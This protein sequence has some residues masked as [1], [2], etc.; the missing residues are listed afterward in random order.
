MPPEAGQQSIGV[1]L[2]A[3]GEVFLRSESGIRQ[4]EAGAEVFRGEELVTGS[5][6]AAEVRFVDDTLLSQGADSKI[7]LDDYVFSDS[8]SDA[9]LLFKMSQG[10]FRMVTGKIA[11]QNPDRFQVGTPLATI[12]IRGTTIISEIIPGGGEK[13]GVEEI[14]AGKALLV[15]SLSGEIRAISSPRELVDIAVSGQLGSVRSMSLAEFNSFREIAPSA[16]QQEREIRQQ[17]EEQQDTPENQVPEDQDTED[18]G[19]N[20][21]GGDEGQTEGGEIGGPVVSGEG[22]LNPAGGVLDPGA[23]VVAHAIGF[24]GAEAILEQLVEAADPESADEVVAGLEELAEEILEAVESGDGEAVQ[25][26]LNALGNEVSEIIDELV[27]GNLQQFAGQTEEQ[28]LNNIGQVLA[29][30]DVPE[31]NSE[32]EG[33]TYTSSDGTNFIHGDGSPWVGTDNDDYYFGAETCESLSGM[34]GNDVIYGN[35]GNDTISGGTGNDSVTGNGGNDIITGNSGN[36]VLSGGAGEDTINGGGGT[37]TISGGTEDDVII[38][39]SGYYDLVDGGDG[40]DTLDLSEMSPVHGAFVNLVSSDP[41]LPNNY[42]GIASMDSEV[43]FFTDIERVIGTAESDTILGNG[44]DNDFFGGDGADSISGAGGN[45]SLVG[46]AGIDTLDGGPGTDILEGGLGSDILDGGSDNDTDKFWYNLLAEAGDSIKN[47]AAGTDKFMFNY[48]EFSVSSP[49][50]PCVANSGYDGYSGTVASGG[51]T[52]KV[53]I[54]VDDGV[55][56]N[57]DYLWYDDNGTGVSGGATL[58]ATLEAGTSMDT[59]DV[60]V[61]SA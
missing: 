37:D 22:V 17:R 32:T 60:E 57:P 14:H 2:A 27:S 28:I 3:N 58:I 9:E 30:N 21:Q 23:G 16:I 43:T 50:T 51:S 19:Q 47:F 18:Q 1:V 48:T 46:G 49:S 53:F 24:T 35:G 39:S 38:A 36:D 33:Q 55:A 54:L 29:D 26:L 6:S 56:M 11:E 10:T 45:D 42:T 61:F 7:S 15:Q 34:G 41:H 5:G 12:G 59:T 52:D 44:A 20:A 8:S 25:Q 4:V 40:I 13:I 31:L